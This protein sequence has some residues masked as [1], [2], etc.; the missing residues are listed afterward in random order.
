[1]RWPHDRGSVL[2]ADL[3]LAAVIVIAIVSIASG[4]GVLAGRQQDQREAARHAA[5][6]AA[7]TGDVSA[8]TAA[9]RRLS[10][11]SAVSIVVADDSV[12]AEVSANI[13]V[14]HPV[15]RRVAVAVS[16]LSEVPIAPYRSGR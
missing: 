16:A 11:S 13:A 2:L 15:L 6:V 4:F 12:T 7:R 10:P 8:A 1:M 3:A 9:A 5:V 14:P